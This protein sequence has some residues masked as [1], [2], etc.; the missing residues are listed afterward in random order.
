MELLR[1]YKFRGLRGDTLSFS[2][3]DEIRL[4]DSIF[5][6]DFGCDVEWVGTFRV[7]HF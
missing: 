4:M 7:F 3:E 2:V 5:T 6:S 1:G